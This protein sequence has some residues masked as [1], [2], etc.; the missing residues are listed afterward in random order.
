MKQI[1]VI[2]LLLFS[3]QVVQADVWDDIVA[4]K[5]TPK[6]IK[7]MRSMK[8]GEHYTMLDQNK[9]VLKYSYKTGQVVDTL[10][11]AD[12]T[13]LNSLKTIT[14]YTF[15]PDERKMLVYNNPK[16]RYR[17]SFTAN[18][19]VFDIKRNELKPL[20]EN[21][22]QEAPLFSPDS[23]YIAFA[24][25]N[26]LYL[27]K[28]DFGT[29][30][31]ITKDG[32]EGKI[33]NGIA[34]WVYEEEFSQT[35]Y[36]VF[37]PD[38]KLLAFV[39]FDE[40]DVPV[41]EMQR[42]LDGD[43][44]QDEISLYP[45][46][47]K[48]KY[49]K[50]GQANSRV[51]VRVYDDFYKSV[52]TINLNQKNEDFYIPRIKW[53]NDQDKLA[54]FIMNRNQN[55]L[56]M[57]YANPKSLVSQ[58]ILRETSDTYVDYGLIDQIYFTKDSK[59]FTYVSERDGYRHAYLYKINGVL[60]KQLT[61]GK[62]DLTTLYGYDEP[63][64]TLY[65]ES[66][67]ASPMQ[68]DIYSIDRKGKKK[69]LTDGKGV[70]NAIFSSN[71]DYLIDFASSLKEP[72]VVTLRDNKGN[73]VRTLKENKEVAENFKT[74]GMSSK[75]FFQFTTPENV[76]LNGWILKPKNFNPNKEYPLLMVQYSGPNSQ[77]VLDRWSIDW[78]YLLAE[79]G[80]VVACVDG[81]GTGARG[82]AF[83]H[84]TY[85][86]LGVL[87]TTDQVSA[88]KYLG[89]L[90]YIDAERIGIWGW[91]FGGFMTLNAMSSGSDVFKAGIAV[92]PV[93][94]WRLY[95]TAYTER[96]MRTPQENVEGYDA[97]S[98]IRKADK[99]SGKLLIIH[100]TADDNVHVQNT[101]LYLNELVKH[102]KNAE[103]YLYTDKN[104]SIPGIETR[105][106]LYR[107][108]FDFLEQNLKK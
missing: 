73:V 23:R 96:F 70:H 108:K 63:T 41:Y 76:S 106:H 16:Y 13:K 2:L 30:S 61:S 46:L 57:L 67:E 97:G 3:F 18:Y 50:A 5:Y 22:A 29:E 79:N 66:A 51:S 14:D 83:T 34:D 52:R 65:Y 86:Q 99:L 59:N 28:L 100:G 90:N 87:E 71:F 60:E 27:H 81:R 40:T 24:R 19:Y 8:D 104:H 53:T 31:A 92:A 77:Q 103:L 47:Q 68:R 42:Y 7:G 56:D 55:Q 101:Y 91:S 43:I 89:K 44:K 21:G 62:W 25:A 10:F 107:K 98:P 20:S 26:N 54:I 69:R 72:L 17:R 37:S 38:S 15:S 84:A 48:F 6:S 4:G 80:Y 88:A 78:E 9:R 11:N 49:P 39:R 102:G 45:T 75:E 35:R 85:K 32:E 58:L 74:S 36:F 64:Q 95:N 12:N 1:V 93:T 105:K 33:I 82:K 94:D